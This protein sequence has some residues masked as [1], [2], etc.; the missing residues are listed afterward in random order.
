[1]S[2]GR[3]SVSALDNLKCA[4]KTSRRPSVTLLF[5]TTAVPATRALLRSVTDV[6]RWRFQLAAEVLSCAGG[7]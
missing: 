6:Q 3:F 2:G 4:L 5:S 7:A 1:L